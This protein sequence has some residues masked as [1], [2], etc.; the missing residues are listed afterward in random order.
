MPTAGLHG[1]RIMRPPSNRIVWPVTK[2]VDP[3]ASDIAENAGQSA[4][5]AKKSAGTRPAQV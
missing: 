4:R 2:A 3:E 5:D 1:Q